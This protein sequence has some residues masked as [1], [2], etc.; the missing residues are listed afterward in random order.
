MTEYY[1]KSLNGEEIP[2]IITVKRG[3]SNMTLR[4]KSVPKREIRITKPYLMTKKQAIRFVEEKR[5]WLED[6]FVAAPK[7]SVINSGDEIEFLGKKVKIEHVADK[8]ST[9]II[10]NPAGE[11]VL[12]V[13]GD[14][15][16]MER[17]IRDFI[18]KEFLI[19][20][21]EIIK[22]SPKE[23][24]PSRLSVRDT[25]S[26]WGSCSTSGTISL[27]WRLAFAPIDVMRY[28]IV[29]EQAHL[30]HMD[31]SVHFWGCVS[32]LYGDGVGRAK[33]WLS[34][35]GAGLHKLF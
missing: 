11:F 20:A 13:G 32:H 7:K 8:Y 3:L 25:T 19:T 18:K 24:W 31:H 23:F 30:Q 28:V 15:K 21:K 12:Q 34:K 22:Q 14:A 33:L 5:K 27:S 9:K 29:H 1:F 4:P 35:N 2:I 10:Q 26:R 16:M 17:R 6:F